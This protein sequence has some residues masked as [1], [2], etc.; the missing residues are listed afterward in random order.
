MGSDGCDGIRGYERTRIQGREVC[1]INFLK[2]H[3]TGLGN[4]VHNLDRSAFDQF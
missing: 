2:Y 4:D 3:T 1:V